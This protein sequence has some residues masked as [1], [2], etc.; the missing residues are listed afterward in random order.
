MM[1]D[2]YVF[3]MDG[4][5]VDSLPDLVV[6]TN[7][8][9]ESVGYPTHT[10][11]EVKSYVGNGAEMLVRRACPA[12]A[13]PDIVDHVLATWRQLYP[14]YGLSNTTPFPG[15]VEAVTQLKAQG[16]KVAVVSNKFQAALQKVTEHYYPG[17]F[18]VVVGESP[19]TPR[20]PDPRGLLRAIEEVGSV[21]ERAV[22]VGDTHTDLET[23]ENAG[24]VSI[25]MDWGYDTPSFYSTCRADKVISSAQ[26][27]LDFAAKR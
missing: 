25:I 10:V 7:M 9:L 21:P 1:F 6:L 13:D 4:T 20:K 5:L 16:K 17:L 14:V 3:D 2:T 27:L 26:E 23:A 12:G 24:V 11:E 19:S 15:M 18:D 22:F 8:A